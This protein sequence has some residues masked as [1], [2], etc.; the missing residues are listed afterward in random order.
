MEATRSYDKNKRPD[1]TFSSPGGIE[2]CFRALEYLEA[3]G[4]PS[5]SERLHYRLVRSPTEMEMRS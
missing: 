5:I 4:I 1:H 2:F 3:M